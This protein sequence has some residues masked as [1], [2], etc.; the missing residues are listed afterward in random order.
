MS[1][2]QRIGVFGGT[3]DPIHRAHLEIARAALDAAGLDRVL[4][5]VAARPP[6]KR[7]GPCAPAEHRYAMVERALDDEPAMAPCRV[8]L[9]RPGPSYMADTL[10]DIQEEFPGAELFLIIGMDSLVDLPRWRNP[11]RILASARLL[12]APRPG[13]WR[14]AA[15][16]EGAYQS[17]PFRE[18]MLSSTEVRD[19]IAAGGDLSDVLPP[20]VARY[21]EEHGL[22]DARY[23][24]AQD[25]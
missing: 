17:L 15:E 1:R 21:V 24:D 16:L 8:E 11:D 6:H 9:D 5:V 12:V 10:R 2:P 3:F 25:R 23:S 22:Y 4:F 14:I 7:G 13:D 18:T 20:A 19:R